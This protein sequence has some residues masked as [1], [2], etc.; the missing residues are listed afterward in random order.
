MIRFRCNHCQANLEVPDDKAGLQR[1]CPRCKKPIRAPGAAVRSAAARP[2][3]AAKSGAAA[4]AA[5]PRTNPASPATSPASQSARGQTPL[6]L[7]KPALLVGVLVGFGVLLIVVVLLINWGTSPSTPRTRAT[8]GEA[9]SFTTPPTGFMPS[10]P[11]NPSAPARITT[12]NIDEL[13]K[14]LSNIDYGMRIQA[15]RR[16][17]ELGVKAK[18]AIEALSKALR[19]PTDSQLSTT[20]RHEAAQALVNMG[21]EALPALPALR[22]A[23]QD[24]YSRVR[25][26]ATEALGNIGKP[27]V[28]AL[29]EALKHT[30]KSV[31]IVAAKGLGKMGADA[32]PAVAA[33]ETGMEDKEPDVRVHMAGALARINPDTP[34][35]VRVLAETLRERDDDVRG[36][37]CMYLGMLG[38]KAEFAVPELTDIMK[39]DVNP[40]IRKKAEEA[41]AKIM[42]N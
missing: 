15:A 23:L 21:A 36:N 18:P 39:L 4:V 31:R 2:A 34:G 12:D 16:L 32:L 22:E 35:V 33:L 13:I 1:N 7:P 25:I 40:S 26:L 5:P 30:D 9:V 24:K 6:G 27:A 10:L 28:P 11:V 37:A 29:I 41:L 17:A 8:S 3:S 38:K 42:G 20:L 19:D 14:L